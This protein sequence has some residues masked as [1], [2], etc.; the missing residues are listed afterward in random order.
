MVEA[1]RKK[2]YIIRTKRAVKIYNSN[3]D[4]RYLFV[5]VADLFAKLLKSDIEYLKLGEIEKISMASKWCPSLDSLQDQRTLLCEGIARRVFPRDSDPEYKDIEEV[6]YADRVRNRLWQEVLD[7]LRK[8]LRSAKKSQSEPPTPA[9][10]DAMKKLYVRILDRGYGNGSHS[11]SKMYE[12]KYNA[13][14]EIANQWEKE[15]KLLLPNEIVANLNNGSSSEVVECEWQRLVRHMGNK[16]R[17]KNC[18]AIWD[19]SKTIEATQ[20]DIC[21]SMG[22]L[23]SELSDEPWKG[24]VI[25]CSKNPKLCK[26]EG[27]NL[28]SKIEFMK[29]LEC[30]GN[31][32]FQKVFDLLFEVSEAKKL[33]PSRMV[34]TVYVLGFQQEGDTVLPEIVCWNPR[35]SPLSLL[36]RKKEGVAMV[37]GGSKGSLTT[38]LEE[39]VVPSLEDLLKSIPKPKE[40]MELAISGEDYNDLIVFD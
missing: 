4:Y 25:T 16:G 18:L 11:F 1:L 2:R 21:A 5:C 36:A 15:S 14:L 13:Y 22:I 8:A 10:S 3:S 9:L 38:M 35:D 31:L 39:N 7:P 30:D 17:L 26:I 24:K 23:I 40:L 19:T 32:D 6:H 27:D 29:G 33:S 37:R 34:K 20:I 28:Q 12:D